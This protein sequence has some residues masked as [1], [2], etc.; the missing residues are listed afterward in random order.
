[1]NAEYKRS[2]SPFREGVAAVICEN[3]KSPL[4]IVAESNVSD[5]S[6]TREGGA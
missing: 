4:N 5:A 3:E 6:V 1:V 2:L